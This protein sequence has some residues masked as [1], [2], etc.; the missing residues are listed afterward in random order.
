MQS[1]RL[2]DSRFLLEWHTDAKGNAEFNDKPSEQRARSVAG[3]LVRRSVDP[4]RLM[5]VG[6]GFREPLP[7]EA[8]LSPANKRVRIIAVD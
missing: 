5:A 6:K 7:G 8:P 1:D 3:Y 2:R 4:R